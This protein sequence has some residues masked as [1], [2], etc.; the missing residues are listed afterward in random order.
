MQLILFWEVFVILFWEVFVNE[1]KK[2]FSNIGFHMLAEGWIEPCYSPLSLVFSQVVVFM[3][4]CV[5]QICMVAC[6]L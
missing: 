1:V 5:F 4:R 3:F 6:F 2:L